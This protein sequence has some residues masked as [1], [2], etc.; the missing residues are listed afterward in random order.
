MPFR[1]YA[2]AIFIVLVF[3][4]WLTYLGTPQEYNVVIFAFDG[5]QA[6]HLHAYGYP[7][8]TTPNL[9]AFLA[10]SYRFENTVSPASWTV[11][12][13]M[14]I[15]T[16]TYP[17]EHRLTNKLVEVETTNA[18]AVKEVNL[19]V[20]A[21]DIDTLAEIL[22]RNGY[23]TAAF[24]GDAGVKGSYG[25]ANGFD[26]Y[27]DA[28]VFGGLDNSAPRAR[29]WL[30]DHMDEKFFLFVH[31][32][33][34]HGQYTPKEGYDYRYVAKGY[35]GQYSGSSRE[36]S[37]LRE[38]GLTAGSLNVADADK[39]FW[40]A[41]YDEKINDAD[42]AFGT[43][44]NELDS[45]GLAEKTIVI[46][47]SDHGTEFFEHGRVDHGH[48]LYGELLD[49]LFAI[50][51]PGQDGRSIPSLVSTMDLSPTLLSILGIRDELA[52]N[53]FQGV[54]LT[55]SFSGRDVSHDVYSETVYRLYTHK[56][57][58]TTP[59][60]WKFILTRETNGRELYNIATDSGEQKN[61]V[62]S[63]P[64]RAYELE[65]KLL[66]HLKEVGDNGPWRIG[67][68]AVYA[69]QCN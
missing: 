8:E 25:Y 49:V 37:V 21:P 50:R 62:D 10:D 5:L 55:P 51:V 15:F 3:A 48:T 30:K 31:G 32:Y 13:F 60:G 61:V 20:L 18:M 4:G 47:L 34:V 54:D 1:N 7:L 38:E 45:L 43:F 11:P 17:S 36:Q 63:E 52:R 29:E 39:E 9:E 59:D 53:Q 57:S 67:C 6:R 33:D 14:S 44:L 40:R 12:S 28:E 56:R 69:D 2:V 23:Q 58:V 22:K 65:Q 41:I 26:E 66:K 16:S 64:I 19:D 46:V 42:A 35:S 27:Y 68:L 24:T